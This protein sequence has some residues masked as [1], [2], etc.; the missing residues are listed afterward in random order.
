MPDAV[1]TAASD[2]LK[3]RTFAIRSFWIA[4]CLAVL[5][6][7]FYVSYLAYGPSKFDREMAELDK[8]QNKMVNDQYRQQMQGRFGR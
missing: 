7:C 2:Y 4:A 6:G 1:Q 3:L 5:G 8:L